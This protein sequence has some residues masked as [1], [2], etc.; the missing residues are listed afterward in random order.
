VFS[1]IQTKLFD[2]FFFNT[3]ETNIHS[4]CSSKKV[5]EKC[6]HIHFFNPTEKLYFTNG[7]WELWWRG[8]GRGERQSQKE[9]EREGTGT[10]EGER[11]RETLVRERE[12]ETP[13]SVCVR[14]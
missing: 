5:E 6:E 14:V 10:G 12:R 9:K 8:C 3:I 2:I 13:V 4:L 7:S 11:E 1:N